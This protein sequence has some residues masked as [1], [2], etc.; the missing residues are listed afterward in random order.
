MPRR[1]GA[2][3]AK[4][5]LTIFPIRERRKGLLLSERSQITIDEYVYTRSRAVPGSPLYGKWYKKRKN[6]AEVEI[7]DY[8]PVSFF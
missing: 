7:I 4:K 1:Q 8:P 6:G 2:V 3:A 5:H